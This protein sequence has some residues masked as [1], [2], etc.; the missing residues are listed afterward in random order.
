MSLWE[1]GVRC[2]LA[3]D[4]Q[5]A[6]AAYACAY[7][8]GEAPAQPR[9]VLRQA[10][11]LDARGHADAAERGYHSA[12]D[13]PEAD[14]AAAAWHN[15]YRYAEMRGDTDGSLEALEAVIATGDP[16]ET[17]RA[18]RNLGT[19][20][21]DH[22]NNTEGARQAYQAA[23]DTQHPGH[24][25][26]A[27]VNL[28]QLLQG[29]GRHQDAAA[30]FSQAIDSGHPVE[31]ARAQYLLAELR[32]ANGQAA[33]A[34]ELF[35]SAM[36]SGNEEWGARAALEAGG[37][38]LLQLEQPDRAVEALV[39]AEC[40]PDPEPA[41]LAAMFRGM[42]EQA[43]GDVAEAE[44]AFRRALQMLPGQ[45]TQ[46]GCLAA[47]NL[48]T[49]YLQRNDPEAAREP[50]TLAAR[51]EDPEERARALLLLGL[52][53]IQA[54]RPMDA[55]QAFEQA[56][57]VRGAPPDVQAMARQHLANLG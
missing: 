24:S 33:E 49:M 51:T 47:K 39:Q 44:A 27:R 20:L 53:E 42:A 9:A 41:Q 7:E 3:G 54:G 38:Y 14:V 12:C 46:P 18:Y 25:Q 6:L 48:G 34:L 1:E 55:R 36:R 8:S 45:V 21:E 4:R 30:L 26:G 31:A 19:F 43:R 16:E 2:E 40:I 52:C 5:G 32:L 23:I 56:A 50:L 11:M 28:G 37:M 29:E 10:E 35:E 13:A 17:P 57:N 22:L 15:L